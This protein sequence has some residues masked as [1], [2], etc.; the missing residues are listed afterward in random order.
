[1]F[2]REVR[3]F[4]RGSAPL[5]QSAGEAIALPALAD[6]FLVKGRGLG[7]MLPRLI[8]KRLLQPGLPTQLH[9][10]MRGTIIVPAA[11]Y[12]CSAVCSIFVVTVR[13]SLAEK[14]RGQGGEES[15]PSRRSLSP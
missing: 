15:L 4:Y 10:L 14:G 2:R 3:C 5:L 12:V 13:E 8:K 9:S 1:M 6:K 7:L 11:H